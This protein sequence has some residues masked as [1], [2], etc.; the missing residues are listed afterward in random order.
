MIIIIIISGLILVDDRL[1]SSYN[2]DVKKFIV[3]MMIKHPVKSAITETKEQETTST[4]TT[5]G[6]KTK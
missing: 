1:V 4:T 3:V 5:G 2:I 6:D